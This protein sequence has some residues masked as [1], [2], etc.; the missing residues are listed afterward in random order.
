TLAEQQ[1]YSLV[2][3]INLS[4]V[5]GEVDHRGRVTLDLRNSLSFKCTLAE[6][7]QAQNRIGEAFEGFIKA[8]PRHKRV[9]ELGTL[10]LKGYNPLTPTTFYIR[11]QAAPGAKNARAANYGEGG[12][13]VFIALRG[14]PS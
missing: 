3:S 13:L 7:L 4:M 2:M 5:V 14:K 8:L 9:F 11:T 6:Q 10:D 12:V 1:G